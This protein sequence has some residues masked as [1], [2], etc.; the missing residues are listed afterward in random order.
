AGLNLAAKVEDGRQVLVPERA[1]AVAA[2]SG[3]TGGSSEAATTAGAAAATAGPVNLNTATLEQLDVLP[4]IGPAMAQRILDH[5]EANGG[6]TSVD[7]LSD[8]PGIGDVRMAA[9]RE[10]VRV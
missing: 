9:L 8:V 6:F 4:G 10:Q 2:S 3:G 1:P 5:R 7:E